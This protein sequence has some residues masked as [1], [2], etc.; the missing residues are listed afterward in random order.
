MIG[1]AIGLI[2]GFV[3]GIIVTAGVFKLAA[4]WPGEK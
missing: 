2:I 3:A 4:H 1:L